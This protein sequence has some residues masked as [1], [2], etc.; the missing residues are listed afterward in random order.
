MPAI[1]GG[2]PPQRNEQ[3][4]QAL[5]TH[6]TRERQRKKQGKLSSL[7]DD[8]KIYTFMM[9]VCLDIIVVNIFNYNTTYFYVF[10]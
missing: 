8:M 1:L 5:K 3:M 4:W 7:C 2:A 6:I 10:A 9:Y